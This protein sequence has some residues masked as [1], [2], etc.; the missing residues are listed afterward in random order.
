MSCLSFW[1]WHCQSILPTGSLRSTPVAAKFSSFGP[2]GG[3]SRVPPLG[4]GGGGGPPPGKFGLRVSCSKQPSVNIWG[5]RMWVGS[6]GYETWPKNSYLYC[7]AKV[8]RPVLRTNCKCK[9]V[10]VILGNRWET[11]ICTK[12]FVKKVFLILSRIVHVVLINISSNT[13]SSP[14]IISYHIPLK[15]KL[16]KPKFSCRRGQPATPTL[17][18]ELCTWT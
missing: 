11:I 6:W 13:G 14:A 10:L 4:G 9:S 15:L 8:D 17:V 18:L 1:E 12:S 5:K 7:I 2:G 16:S 3:C